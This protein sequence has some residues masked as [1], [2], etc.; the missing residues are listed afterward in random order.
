MAPPSPGRHRADETRG[1]HRTTRP[2]VRLSRLRRSRDRRAD[3]PSHRHL[4]PVAAVAVLAGSTLVVVPTASAAP[5]CD[6]AAPGA[7]SGA[8]QR[9]AVTYDGRDV[10]VSN[11]VFDASHA[12][13]LVRVYDGRV[14]FDHVTF[15]GNGTGG[16]GHTLEVKQGGSVE[17]YNSV[18]AGSPSE[19]TV[20]FHEHAGTSTI[21]CSAFRSAP[22]EDHLD[23]KP[24]SGAVVDVRD[25]AF[26]AGT[27]GGRTVQ[28]AGSGG[29]QN[30]VGNTGMDNVFYEEGATGTLENNAITQLD[31]YDVSGVDVI[32][33]TI[34]GVKHG[35]G[36]GD[37]D[38]TGVTYVN[39]EID[40]FA[41]NGGSCRASGNA[42]T[43]MSACGN[44]PAQDT[45]D[46]G[47]T[48]STDGSADSG[49][50]DGG[51]SS[52]DSTNSE[53]TDG[54]TNGGSSGD[55]SSTDGP[56]A[57]DPPTGEPA[58]SGTPTEASSPSGTSTT[59]GKQ[60]G[61]DRRDGSRDETRHHAREGD[62][63]SPGWVSF[64]VHL[65]RSWR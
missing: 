22:G 57:G 9:G 32:A 55:G 18:F 21:A 50:S 4:L 60:C 48:S 17:V 52:G 23:V 49:S 33:N 14:V 12:D 64:L 61:D 43:D 36:S 24:S 26:P 6:G 65:W 11:V 53:S 8:D 13:D 54:D 19:D 29:T 44:A 27:P 34:G 10:T 51:A 1:R 40:D 46:P 25:N 35:E 7:R 5:S 3:R 37:R 42:G 63:G 16:S 45:A 38:P 59:T 39:N 47:P 62:H 56:G 31:L 58:G 2:R 30:F 20:Q 28:N 15:R 41:F